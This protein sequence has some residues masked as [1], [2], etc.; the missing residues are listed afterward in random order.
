MSKNTN[1]TQENTDLELQ[2]F[3]D[4]VFPPEFRDA[5]RLYKETVINILRLLEDSSQVFS[6]TIPILKKYGFGK[7]LFA[8]RAIKKQVQILETQVEDYE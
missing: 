6:S 2:R 3:R 8:I 4:L 1:N 7:G 5:D